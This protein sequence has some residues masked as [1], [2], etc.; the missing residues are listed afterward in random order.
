M[1]MVLQVQILM[2]QKQKFMFLLTIRVKS[3]G[4]I[5][6]NDFVKGADLQY[7]TKSFQLKENTLI[8]KMLQVYV[9]IKMAGILNQL[10]MAVK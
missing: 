8:W 4:E 7:F 3:H 2:S 1:N 9:I 5:R 6:Y 10:M